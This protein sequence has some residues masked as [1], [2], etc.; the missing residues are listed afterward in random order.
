MGFVIPTVILS[1]LLAWYWARFLLPIWYLTATI[2]AIVLLIL[3]VIGTLVM[4]AKAPGLEWRIARLIKLREYQK[5]QGKNFEWKYG[6][7]L[8]EGFKDETI[9]L[10]MPQT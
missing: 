3:F 8:P 2:I 7:P 6:A 10:E 4:R 9:A 5:A 1:G